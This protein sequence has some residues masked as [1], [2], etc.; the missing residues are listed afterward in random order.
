MGEEGF[1]PPI[2]TLS[3]W[4]FTRLSYPP[5]VGSS[6]LEPEPL[7]RPRTRQHGSGRGS[8]LF[9][10]TLSGRGRVIIPHPT[11]TEHRLV[12]CHWVFP[13]LDYSPSM[14]KGRVGNSNPRH[15]RHKVA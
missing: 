2:T 13:A 14:V 4:C 8:V 7:P 11:A 6:G 3:E 9:L 10:L 12:S 1:E 15:Y 5:A